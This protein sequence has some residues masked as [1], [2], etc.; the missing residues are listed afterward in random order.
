MF[1][2]SFMS[3][4]CINF[5]TQSMHC[6]NVFGFNVQIFLTGFED[7]LYLIMWLLQLLVALTGLAVTVVLGQSQHDIADPPPLPEKGTFL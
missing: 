5:T 2:S 4:T 6:F 1:F 3:F 7:I